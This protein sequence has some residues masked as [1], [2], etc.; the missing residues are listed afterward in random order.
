MVGLQLG[1]QDFDLLITGPRQLEQGVGSVYSLL[2]EH[3]GLQDT[4]CFRAIAHSHSKS[5][6][7]TTKGQREGACDLR[8]QDESEDEPMA[9]N[10]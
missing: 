4:S 9:G 10:W 3:G 5:P 6:K 2:D 7:L 1:L 8:P